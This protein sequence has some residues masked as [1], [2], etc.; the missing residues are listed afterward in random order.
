MARA[1]AARNSSGCAGTCQVGRT[2]PAPH[3]P[4]DGR[5][6]SKY[7]AL[8]GLQ[9]RRRRLSKGCARKSCC[10]PA[11]PPEQGTAPPARRREKTRRPAASGSPPARP[12]VRWPPPEVPPEP[13]TRPRPVPGPLPTCARPCPWRAGRSAVGDRGPAAGRTQVAG[14]EQPAA[15]GSQ[16]PAPGRPR[17]DPNSGGAGGGARGRAPRGARL[18]PRGLGAPF[19]RQANG[20]PPGTSARA[21]LSRPDAA[22]RGTPS[23]PE[24]PGP[25]GARLSQR[26]PS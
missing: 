24:I 6:A 16:G 14:G 4:N 17:P 3:A 26:L 7:R 23:S 19:T 5:P 25:P 8:P 22:S 10:Q 13:S 18:F 9:L 11:P 20:A 2:L 1:S 21:R 15:C 12:E